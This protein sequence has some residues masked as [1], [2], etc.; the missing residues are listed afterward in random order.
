MTNESLSKQERLEAELAN[1]K[2]DPN[3]SGYWRDVSG[4]KV[5]IQCK[6]EMFDLFIKADSRKMGFDANAEISNIVE[7]LANSI[8]ASGESSL[9]EYP[10]FFSDGTRA[11]IAVRDDEHRDK[12]ASRQSRQ[13]GEMRKEILRSDQSAE[14]ESRCLTEAEKIELLHEWYENEVAAVEEQSDGD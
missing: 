13:A 12:V 10:L 7:G 4:F 11:G 2:P 9:Q 5:R 6:F 3:E 1:S 14:G 8:K